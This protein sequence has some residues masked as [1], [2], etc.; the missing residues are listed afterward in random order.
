MAPFPSPREAYS[1]L[2]STRSALSLSLTF[3][4][5]FAILFATKFPKSGLVVYEFRLSGDSGS[6]I[7]SELFAFLFYHPWVFYCSTMFFAQTQE[8]C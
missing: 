7:C 3:P 5:R 4:L 2:T 8:D 1:A 6:H